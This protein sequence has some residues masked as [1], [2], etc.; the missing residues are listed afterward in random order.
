MSHRLDDL[1]PHLRALYD[2]ELSLG[3]VIVR[4]DRDAWTQCPLAVVFHDPLHFDDAK[5]LIIPDCVKRWES[6][7]PH[8]AIEAGWFCEQTRHSLSGPLK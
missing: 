8:Y 4:T 7:D 3:N 2:L 5:Q 6:R 1:S